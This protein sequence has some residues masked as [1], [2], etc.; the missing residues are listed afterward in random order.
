[1]VRL[2]SVR[3]LLVVIAILATIVIPLGGMASAAPG[4]CPPEASGFLAYPVVG[5]VGDPAPAPDTDPLWD[6]LASS[7]AEE[8]LTLQHLVELS[9]SGSLDGLYAFVVSGWL[10]W[11]RNG[12]GMICVQRFPSDQQ[13]KPAFF[14]NVI[15]NNAQL[16]V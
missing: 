3:G 7:A 16:P 8:G 5:S 14:W 6:L 11:D 12:D 4:S 2:R 9:G 15:D 1:V 10:G 13:G